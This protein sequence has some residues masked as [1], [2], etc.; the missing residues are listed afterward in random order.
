MEFCPK[1]GSILLVEGDKTPVCAKCGHKHKGK[2]KLQVS[3]K[4]NA[5]E[6]V[7]VVDEAKMSTYPIVEIKCPEC[8]NKDANRVMPLGCWWLPTRAPSCRS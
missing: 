8:K 5:P 1:C 3:E 4:M 2:L 7:A 6:R